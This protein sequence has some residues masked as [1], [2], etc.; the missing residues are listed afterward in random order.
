MNTTSSLRGSTTSTVVGDVVRVLAGL[1]IPVGGALYGP[2]AV[3]LLSLVLLGTVLPRAVG[4]QG[5]VDPLVGLVLSVAAWIALLDL[6]AR[7]SWLD[8]VMHLLAT[9]AL[10]VLAYA[11]LV[12]LGCLPTPGPLLAG[13][14]AA[15]RA[16]GP[17]LRRP[18]TGAVVTATALG[19]L[20]AL[21]WEVGEWAGAQYVDPSIDVGYL[22]TLGDLVAGG[23]GAFVAG[24]LLVRRS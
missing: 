21:L 5:V 14:D 6:Y 19:V 3:A 7:V 13:P 24:L 22:D 12:F 18:R 1:A 8:L 9:A 23:I 2:V 15:A 11:V 10:T 4:L 17:T 20:L 16:A